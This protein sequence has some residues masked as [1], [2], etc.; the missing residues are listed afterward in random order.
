MEKGWI[1]DPV[2]HGADGQLRQG[3]GEDAEKEADGVEEN[4][5]LEVILA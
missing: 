4:G 2:Q 1:E 3:E 5:R